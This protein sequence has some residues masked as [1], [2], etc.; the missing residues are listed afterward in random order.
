MKK[1]IPEQATCTCDRCGTVLTSRNTDSTGRINYAWRD[2]SGCAVGGM[3]FDFDL[4]VGC[5]AD[6]RK[7]MESDFSDD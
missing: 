2:Y 3:K 6:L 1:V 5:T 7:F 4:C